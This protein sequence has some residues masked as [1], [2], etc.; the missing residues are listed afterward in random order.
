MMLNR[1]NFRTDVF[2]GH[3]LGTGTSS[4]IRVVVGIWP[5]S[6]LGSFSDCMIAMPDGH[7]VL[8]APDEAVASYVGSTYS[9]DE[10]RIVAVD[11]R[12]DED[13]VVVTAG[14][15]R[16][17][18]DIGRVTMLGRLLGVI[19]ESVSVSTAFARLCDP[20][21]RVVMPGVRTVGSAGNGR[22]EF[23]SARQVRAVTGVSGEFGGVDL[24]ALR[25]V[26]PSPD[27]GFS[28]TPRTPALT[29]VTTTVRVPVPA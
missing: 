24:G 7:R 10:V 25:P 22:L 21:A 20:V 13:V 16:L 1:N 14:D 23:Y 26:Q 9:F 12:V 5:L 18:A 2:R 29:A 27:F 8:L 28:S 6:P 4:G 15:L 3:I 11:A 19:P 17:R